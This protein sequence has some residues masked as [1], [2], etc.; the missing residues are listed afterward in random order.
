[1]YQDN[2]KRTRDSGDNP[3]AGTGATLM[4]RRCEGCERLLAPLFDAC[5][6]CRSTDLAWVPSSGAG[7]IVSCRVLQ[8]AANPRAETKRST[9]AI[10]ELDEGPWLYTTIQGEPPLSAAMPVRVRFRA[11]PGGDRFPVFAVNPPTGA[12]P[13][14]LLDPRSEAATI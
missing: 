11:G 4:I 14:R 2:P 6:S 13:T 7:T 8:R 1:M 10:V 3:A 12:S 5:S 9:I